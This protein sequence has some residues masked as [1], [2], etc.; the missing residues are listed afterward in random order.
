MIKSVANILNTGTGDI[1]VRKTARRCMRN[2]CKYAV[3][4]LRHP[5]PAAGFFENNFEL[6]GQ[7]NLDSALREGKGVV[8]VS[9][10]LGNL[11]LGI[12]LLS[13][14]GYPVNAIVDD[15]G[16]AELDA[17]LNRQRAMS[18][19]NLINV[20][21]VTSCLIDVLRKNEI[22]AL[23]ID[24]PN[25]VKGVSVKL[26]QRWILFPT[27]AATLALRTGARLVPCGL[28]RTSNTTYQG[29]IG[30]PVDFVSTGKV[31]ED[32]KLLTQGAVS[33]LEEMSKTFLDQWYVFHPMINDDIPL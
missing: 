8:L 31:A 22:I 30:K 10:H 25:C 33:S 5:F 15:L 26:G 2:Y 6:K 3:D 20:K 9:F 28:V 13:S 17:F 21:E 29:I 32:I 12:R 27:G 19:V 11:D 14:L 23:M 18:R 16:S 1:T 24:C 4:F 7:E